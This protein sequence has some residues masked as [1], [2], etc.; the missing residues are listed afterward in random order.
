MDSFISLAVI[1]LI[2]I[3]MIYVCELGIP[4]MTLTARIET[5]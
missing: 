4:A 2:A 3:A 5:D 1:G